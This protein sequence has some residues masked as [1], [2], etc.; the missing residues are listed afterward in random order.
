[1]EVNDG[2]EAKEVKEETQ[3]NVAAQGAAE[4]MC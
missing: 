4:K 1:M 2:E 3:R